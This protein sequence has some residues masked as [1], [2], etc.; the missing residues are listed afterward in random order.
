MS[1]AD[2][3]GSRSAMRRRG[4]RPSLDDAASRGLLGR[5]HWRAASVRLLSRAVA[6]TLSLSRA[7]DNLFQATCA[8]DVRLPPVEL[9]RALHRVLLRGHEREVD[10]GVG[11]EICG[12]RRL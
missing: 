1:P 9:E 7:R 8:G 3:A 12:V 6:V 5:D 2:R 4:L 11:D 10:E